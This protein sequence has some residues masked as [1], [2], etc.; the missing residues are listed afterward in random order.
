M[1]YNFIAHEPAVGH[2]ARENF[3]CGGAGFYVAEQTAAMNSTTR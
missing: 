3:A 2:L 1:L